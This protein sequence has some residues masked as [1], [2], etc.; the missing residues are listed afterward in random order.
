MIPKFS[1]LPEL[2]PLCCTF[3]PRS[4]HKN[5]LCYHC[6]L[7]RTDAIHS[8][9]MRRAVQQFYQLKKEMLVAFNDTLRRRLRARERAL[10]AFSRDRRLSDAM[11]Q[12]CAE[13]SLELACL[14]DI[15][16]IERA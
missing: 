7:L 1:K 11:R 8:D 12:R 15:L 2:G 4:R 10:K 14:L 13:R 9:R 3:K 6:N 5:A 16:P